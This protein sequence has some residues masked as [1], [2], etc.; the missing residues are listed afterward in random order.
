MA[1]WEYYYSAE[2]AYYNALNAQENMRQRNLVKRRQ[3]PYHGRHRM[4]EIVGSDGFGSFGTV[5]SLWI[6]LFQRN[7]LLLGFNPGKIDDLWGSK[8]RTAMQNYQRARNIPVTNKPNAVTLTGICAEAGM[9]GGTYIRLVNLLDA[10]SP[11]TPWSPRSSMTI[12]EQE[13]A[14]HEAATAAASAGG[15]ARSFIQKFGLKMPSLNTML[16]GGGILVLGVAAFL[17]FKKK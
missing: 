12:T 15:A 10:I 13:V 8:T 6:E 7:L 1:D 17:T 4:A 16:I 2:K 9:K 11:P 14:A 5:R 3:V